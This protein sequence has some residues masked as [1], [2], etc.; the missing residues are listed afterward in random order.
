MLCSVT[1]LHAV[2]DIVTDANRKHHLRALFVR[3]DAK[4][5]WVASMMDRAGVRTIRN[6][7]VHTSGE[8]PSRVLQAWSKGAQS[9]LIADAMVSDDVLHIRACDLR[10]YEIA[11]SQMAALKRI[12]ASQRDTFEIAEDGAFIHWPDSDTHI[13]LE[14]VRFELQPE[15][16]MQQVARTLIHYQRV[17]EGIAQL[18]SEAGLT[19]SEIPGLSERQVRRIESG[20]SV[21]VSALQA[22]AHAHGLAVSDYLNRLAEVSRRTQPA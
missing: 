3:N 1:H 16:K 14:S 17:G 20:A 12:P 13:D 19:Q 5:T 22:L 11:F 10:S 4:D 8:V 7:I 21:T 9:K 2:A 18:R 15:L 6:T